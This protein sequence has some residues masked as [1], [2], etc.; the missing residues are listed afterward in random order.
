MSDTESSA[1]PSPV[2]SVDESQVSSAPPSPSPE[3]A[4]PSPSPEREPTP[5]P[6]PKKRK[7]AASKK[8][9]EPK[10]VKSSSSK[11]E[12]KKAKSA[13]K[14][15]AK[16]PKDP[17][18]YKAPRGRPKSK[19]K[20]SA[21]PKPTRLKRSDI[22]VPLRFVVDEANYQ[23]TLLFFHELLGKMTFK[24]FETWVKRSRAAELKRMKNA[25]K[26]PLDDD[27]TLANYVKFLKE[28]DA[29][30]FEG[31]D[32]VWLMNHGF[33]GILSSKAILANT[34]LKD[35]QVDSKS[36]ARYQGTL[37][38][39]RECRRR[40]IEPKGIVSGKT[41]NTVHRMEKGTDGKEKKVVD[42]FDYSF[43]IPEGDKRVWVGRSSRF[44]GGHEGHPLAMTRTME[45]RHPLTDDQKL[46]AG[47]PM[48]TIF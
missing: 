22:E 44:R 17:A 31:L 29:S 40:K 37:A 48:V 32:G 14:P 43:D 11:G 13:K 9:K 42:S 4:S 1:P 12:P 19:K 3:A 2:S 46:R 34:L 36:V 23:K 35:E 8:V 6:A 45:V 20:D 21:E 7:R 5:P 41:Q 15:P 16:A 26:K 27:A 18:A 10:T 39:F 33:E 25:N 47:T 30:L 38:L 24:K 28:A